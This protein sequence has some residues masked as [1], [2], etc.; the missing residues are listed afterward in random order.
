MAMNRWVVAVCVF[1]ALQISAAAQSLD[2]QVYR[3]RIEPIFLKLREANGPGGTCFMCHTQVKTRFR[4]EPVSPDVSWS[5]EQSRR[6]YEAVMKLVTPGDPLRSRLLLHPLVPR[7][8][9]DAVHSGGKHWESQTD[10]EWQTIAAWIKAGT[11]PAAAAPAPA[12]DLEV[13]KT[14]VQPIFLRKVEGL[15]RCYA[16][17]SQGTNFRLQTLAAGSSAWTE[18]QSR[19]NFGAIQRLVVPGDP[20]SSRLLMMP[21]ATEAGGDPFHPGGKHWASQNDPAWQTIAAWVKG[22][23]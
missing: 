23:R 14:R 12:L 20:L 9:G 18:E 19:M 3:T 8:G 5:E 6:N 1:L 17:H 21:L 2:F 11:P 10:P 13:F 22:Q 16:C 15:A 4:L 7:A